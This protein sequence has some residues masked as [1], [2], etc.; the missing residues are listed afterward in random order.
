[1]LGAVLS[2]P[3]PSDCYI[4]LLSINSPLIVILPFARPELSSC[5]NQGP[6]DNNGI[7]AVALPM[8]TNK[9][10]VF[11]NCCAG[12]LHHQHLGLLPYLYTCRLPLCLF[13]STG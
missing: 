1:M 2:L 13:G 12:A 4:L 3:N 6:W 8:D 7:D 11:H 9:T 5:A 10:A